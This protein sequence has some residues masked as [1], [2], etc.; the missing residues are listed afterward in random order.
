M[1]PWLSVPWLPMVWLGGGSAV[2][3]DMDPW[4]SVP[5]LPLVWPF[6]YLL[7]VTGNP[8][9][10]EIMDPWL[11]VPELPLVWRWRRLGYP[12]DCGPVAF[13]PRVTPGLAICFMATR[14]SMIHGP[15]AFRPRV[16]PGLACLSP[17][18]LH[19]RPFLKKGG[20]GYPGL[21]KIKRFP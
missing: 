3:T 6:T 8:A 20:Y 4:L 10:H 11:S 5:E 19:I 14:L 18:Y 2:H 16:T 7:T 17:F 13:C 1:D 15:V 9:I 21:S 12:H